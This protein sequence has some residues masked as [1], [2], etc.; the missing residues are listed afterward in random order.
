MGDMV[1]E[2][3]FAFIQGR[4]FLGSVALTEEAIAYPRKR[5]TD[6]MLIKIDFENAFDTIDWSILIEALRARSISHTFSGW[7]RECLAFSRATV[8]INGEGRSET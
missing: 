4:S 8:M 3:Q 2:S 7:I 1:D 6:G 5:H